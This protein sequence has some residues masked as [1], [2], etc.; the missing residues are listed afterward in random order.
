[1]SIA[2]K[3]R[4]ILEKE[5]FQNLKNKLPQL[6]NL[7]EKAN[8]EWG[9]EDGFY[10]FYHQSFKVFYLQSITETIVKELSNLMPN[11][12]FNDWFEQIINEGTGKSFKMEDNKNWLAETRPILEAFSHAKFFLEMGVKYG[13]LYEDEPACPFD[14]GWA[15]F[16]YLFNLR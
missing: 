13:S 3:Q 9:G 8:D 14:T 6:V 12:P 7:L 16:L 2:H 1:M 15:A 11:I 5:L 10:R 4:M